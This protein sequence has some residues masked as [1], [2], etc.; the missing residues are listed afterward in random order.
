MSDLL[1][2]THTPVLRSGQ[3]VRT[4]G[5]ARALAAH[6]GLTLLYARFGAAEPDDAFRA[7]PGVELRVSCPRAARGGRSLMRWRAGRACRTTSR[8]GSPAS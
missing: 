4:Y 6:G 3:A 7:I 5:V 1:V 8:G 2:T